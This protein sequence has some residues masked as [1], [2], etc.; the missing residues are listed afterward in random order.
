[1]IASLTSGL[2]AWYVA[3]KG[4]VGVVASIQNDR[5]ALPVFRMTIVKVRCVDGAT[6][7][8]SRSPTALPLMT[9]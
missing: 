8:S 2:F 1:V 4:A 7:N 3:A 9:S 6:D 5:V